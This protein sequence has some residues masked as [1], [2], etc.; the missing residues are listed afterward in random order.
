M[1]GAVGRAISCKVCP[2]A[3]YSVLP[4]VSGARIGPRT[5]L[6]AHAFRGLVGSQY[7]YRSEIVMDQASAN[8]AKDERADFAQFL[9]R[10]QSMDIEEQGQIVTAHTSSV[11]SR[12]WEALTNSED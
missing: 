2:L 6:T 12:D 7:I 11:S 10:L 3:P 8:E 9:D 4:A 1:V 5:L